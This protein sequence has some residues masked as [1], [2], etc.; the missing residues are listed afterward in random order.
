MVRL[1]RDLV[2][3]TLPH[4]GMVL[5][6]LVSLVRVPRPNLGAK[7]IAVVASTFPLWI[8]IHHP[9][10]VEEA[11]LLSRLLEALTIKT[12]IRTHSSSAHVREADSMSKAFSKHAAYVLQAY[13]EAMNDPLCVLP[14]SLR[15]ELYPGL[16]ALCGMLNEHNRNALM[17]S[18]LDS[19]GKSA[20]KALWK[21]Y[22]KQ[23]YTGQG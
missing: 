16:F 3:S 1:R 19:S 22:E 18:A 21:E 12:V 7:Q 5:A 8:D 10:S 13:F 23:Q 6:R 20:M 11:K 17:T 4:L 2:L 9:L 14:P 15:K